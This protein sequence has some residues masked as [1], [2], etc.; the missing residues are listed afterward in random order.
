MIENIL[1]YYYDFENVKYKK[2]DIGYIVYFNNK[3]YY[4]YP[5]FISSDELMEVKG[6]FDVINSIDN[7]TSTIVL[8]RLGQIITSFSNLNYIL[9]KI[10]KNKIIP[11]W[12]LD[13]DKKKYGKLYR[14]D[15]V[16]LWS[17]K[18]DYLEFQ[19]E[20]VKGNNKVLDKYFDYFVGLTENAISLAN[21]TIN[22]Y[23]N[24]KVSIQ[25]KRYDNFF[26]DRP[27]NIIIDYNVRD[28]AELIKYKYFFMDFDFD[29]V[30]KILINLK[31]NDGEKKL[32]FS[33]LLFPSF[34]FDLYD[35]VINNDNLISIENKYLEKIQ[36][37]PVF[38]KKI[39]K[40]E[41]FESIVDD[42][43]WIK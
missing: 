1:K 41:I 23:E 21:N 19:R 10:G 9:V 3:A 26:Y 29:E 7:N 17:S 18:I 22:K 15:W 11:N 40:L 30:N 36:Q 34:Y 2:N 4:F 35:K 20:H 5:T 14:T 39:C 16:G 37:Y 24:L 38:L 28:I 32:L 13:L 43:Q 25:H 31:Y 12:L 8:N 27:T 33:R 6:L 42:F